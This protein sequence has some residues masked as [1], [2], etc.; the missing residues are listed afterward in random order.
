MASSVG[1]VNRSVQQISLAAEELSASSE[2]TEEDVVRVAG[3]VQQQVATANE[4]VTE[5]DEMA[6]LSERLTSRLATFQTS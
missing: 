2:G 3:Q 5:A 1:T 4:L 6:R